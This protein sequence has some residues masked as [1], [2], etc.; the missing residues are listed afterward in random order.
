MTKRDIK[1]R[2]W[3]GREKRFLSE[4]EIR[5]YQVPELNTP[6]LNS[7]GDWEQY[8]EVKD[9]NGVEIY[10]GDFIKTTFTISFDGD[11]LQ[12]IG[13]VG[14]QDNSWCISEEEGAWSNISE[15]VDHGMEVVGNV[16]ENLE[17]LEV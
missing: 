2:L 12:V 4:A 3:D 6:T 17:L 8:T 13:R 9:I 11:Y 5:R 7:C 10:D 15:W 16:H 1:F 14:W